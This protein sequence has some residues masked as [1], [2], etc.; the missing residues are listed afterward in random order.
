MKAQFNGTCK[1]CDLVIKAG[2]H[3]II[4]DSNDNWIHTS[5]S[6]KN[7]ESEISRFIEKDE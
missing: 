7:G 4:K 6:D 3:K 5:C 1:I 2:K